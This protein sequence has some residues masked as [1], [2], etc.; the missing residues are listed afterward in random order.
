MLGIVARQFTTGIWHQ[1]SPLYVKKFKE[2]K[3]L[4]AEYSRLTGEKQVIRKNEQL[5][6]LNMDTL[7]RE[8]N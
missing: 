7:M 3:D 2:R 8:F 6:E 4:E 5:I 1:A